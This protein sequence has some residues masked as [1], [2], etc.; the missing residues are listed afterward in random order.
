G[1]AAMGDAP[2]DP[3]GNELQVIGDLLLEVAIGRAPRHCAERAHAA[4]GFEGAALIKED[5]ARA[6]IRAGKQGADHR[7]AC[8]PASALARSPDV[9]MPPSAIT[10]MPLSAAASA[11]S[12]M[13]VSCG[14]PTPATMRVVQMEPGP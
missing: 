3:F 7:R 2:L 5:F 9:L 6:F 12:M 1:R 8:P 13:A 11:A 14:V 10:G 4:I